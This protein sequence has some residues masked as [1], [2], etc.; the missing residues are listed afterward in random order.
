MSAT[1]PSTPLS[2]SNRECVEDGNHLRKACFSYTGRTI[3]DDRGNPVRLDRATQ[4][5]A[6]AKNVPLTDVFVQR[7]RTHPCRQRGVE[8]AGPV[9]AS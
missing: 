7:A 1:F 8:A 4:Q 6:R 5:L 2:R 3:Q 9:T